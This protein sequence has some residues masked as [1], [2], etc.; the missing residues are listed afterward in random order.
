MD[1]VSYML[2]T[3]KVDCGVVDLALEVCRQRGGN[4]QL[5]SVLSEAPSSPS[6]AKRAKFDKPGPGLVQSECANLASLKYYFGA[7][8]GHSPNDASLL[9][10]GCC[11]GKRW[12]IALTRPPTSLSYVLGACFE[13]TTNPP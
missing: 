11:L 9:V 10:V 6:N 12:E 1:C 3:G 13:W 4:S 7:G 8:E 5:L 2:S